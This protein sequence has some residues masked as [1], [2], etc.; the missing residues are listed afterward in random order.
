MDPNNLNDFD[1]TNTYDH[2]DAFFQPDYDR[3]MRDYESYQHYMSLCE[4]EAGGS[5]S[6]PIRRRRYIYREREEAEERLIDDYFGDDEYEPKYPEETFRRRYRMSSTLFNKIVNDILSYDVQPIPEYFTYFSSRLDTTGRKSIGPILKCTSAIRQLAYST[7]PDAFDEYLQIA[8]RHS[9]LPTLNRPLHL[10]N[11]LVTPN[12]IKNLIFVHQFT[13]DNNCTVKFDAF[14]FSVK[15]FLTRHILLRCD[16]SGDLYPVTSPSPTPHVFLS[17]SPSTW[18]QRLGHPGEDVLRSLKSRQYISY[19]KEKSS[20]LCHA[21][22]LGKHVRLPFTSSNSS[23]TCSFEI[24]HYDIWTSPI[25]SSGGFKYYVLFLDHY[26]HYLWI[27][28]LRTKFEVFQKFLH[29]RSYVNNQFKCDIA[30]FQC[31]HGGEFDNTNLLNLFAQNGI[32]FRFSCPKTSQQNGKSERMIRTINNVIR[33]LLFQAHLPP[34]FWVKALHMAAYLLNLI[35]SSAIQNEIPCTKLFNKQPDYSRLRIFGCLCYP[36]LHSP[37]KLAPRATPCIFL[38]YPAYHRGYRCLDLS[39]NKIIMWIPLNMDL[40]T[41]LRVVVNMNRFT[42]TTGETM[43]KNTINFAVVYIPYILLLQISHIQCKQVL[44]FAYTP[45]KKAEIYGLNSPTTN[46][47]YL[48]TV[49]LSSISWEINLLSMVYLSA[50]AEYRG[51][52]NVV[53][54]TAWLRNLHRE[55]HSPLSTATLVYCD[56]VS[57][58]YMLEFYMCPLA[59]NMPIFSPR[60]CLLPCLKNF[61][62]V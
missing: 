40:T 35:P 28:P 4:Q 60:D 20:H 37:Y 21:C 31:D 25:A 22:Q 17:V 55:L 51:V 46:A 24:V 16:S 23:V 9:I 10:H 59:F 27:Y 19:N 57:A 5:S 32:Q 14:G 26:S 18:H 62:P 41:L 61:D 34:V 36:H 39:T 33:T 38:G 11:V 2:Y 47:G 6:G 52:A 43:I 56:N 54:E 12:I 7:A 44:L 30:A 1:T 8:E 13:R 58:V 53:A 29:F 42:Q 49:I 50:E 3:Y 45:P 15:D 48:D